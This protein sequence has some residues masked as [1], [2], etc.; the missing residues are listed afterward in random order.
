MAVDSELNICRERMDV[1]QPL[2]RHLWKIHTKGIRNAASD[3]IELA[4]DGWENIISR[5]AGKQKNGEAPLASL[6]G[7]MWTG[8]SRLRLD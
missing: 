4:A 7:F 2:R 3:S 5:N 8:A 6:V 1:T